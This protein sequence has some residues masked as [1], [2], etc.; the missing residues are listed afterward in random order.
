M[1]GGL[2]YSFPTSVIFFES[3]VF[4]GAIYWGLLNYIVGENLI[5]D[6]IQVVF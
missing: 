4:V 2:G 3:H 5:C 1:G 6:V